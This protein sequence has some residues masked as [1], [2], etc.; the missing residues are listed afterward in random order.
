MEVLITDLYKQYEYSLCKG[1]PTPK[2]A[3]S[4]GTWYLHFRYMKFLVK[5]IWYN[6]IIFNSSAP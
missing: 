2:I 6:F 4:K 3:E 1:K 5:T